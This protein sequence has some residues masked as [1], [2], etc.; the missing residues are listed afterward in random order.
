MKLTLFQ[1]ILLYKR[2]TLVLKVSGIASSG[3]YA[4]KGLGPSIMFEPVL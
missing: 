1:M 4:V 2:I 3:R